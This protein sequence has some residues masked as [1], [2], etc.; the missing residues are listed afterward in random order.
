MKIFIAVDGSAYSTKAAKHV[1]THRESSRQHV[2]LLLSLGVHSRCQPSTVNTEVV[3][4]SWPSD[5]PKWHICRVLRPV[6]ASS[7]SRVFMPM[8]LKAAKTSAP[9]F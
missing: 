1:M 7:R 9:S 4:R 8:G 2:S 6:N 3:E 5:A